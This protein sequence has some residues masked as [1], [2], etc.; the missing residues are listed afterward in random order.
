MIADE[1]ADGFGRATSGVVTVS[2]NAAVTGYHDSGQ[3]M[4]F[5]PGHPITNLEHRSPFV[6]ESRDIGDDGHSSI[7]KCCPVADI[8]PCPWPSGI[9]EFSHLVELVRAGIACGDTGSCNR[10]STAGNIV[11]IMFDPHLI[12]ARQSECAHL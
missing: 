6:R 4:R 8:I 10:A 12:D 9:D 2:K 5:D 3:S 11:V 1:P 7:A